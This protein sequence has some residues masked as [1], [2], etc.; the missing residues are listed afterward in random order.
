MWYSEQI[1]PM[2]RWSPILTADRPEAK[3]ADGAK[4]R[5][6]NERKVPFEY[7]NMTLDQLFVIFNSDFVPTHMHVAS[8]GLYRVTGR[9]RLEVTNDA[10]YTLVDYENAAGKK[11]AQCADRFDDGRFTLISVEDAGK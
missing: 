7:R 11:F 3:K 1:N 2:G 9:D 4:M 10:A 6:R 5:I 8:G